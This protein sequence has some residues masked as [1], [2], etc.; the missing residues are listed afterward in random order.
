MVECYDV[1]EN[2]AASFIGTD[3]DRDGMILYM[4][5]PF[6]VIERN[7]NYSKKMKYLL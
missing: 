2:S 3:H 6:Q 4:S 7:T 5:V 1:S